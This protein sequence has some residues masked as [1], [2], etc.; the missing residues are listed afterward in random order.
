M[1]IVITICVHTWPYT[2]PLPGY[3][4]LLVDL[5]FLAPALLWGRPVPLSQLLLPEVQQTVATAAK[6]KPTAP[7]GVDQMI[8]HWHPWLHFCSHLE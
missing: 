5:P 3:S 2:P 7:A 8:Q 4:T 6:C 1:V